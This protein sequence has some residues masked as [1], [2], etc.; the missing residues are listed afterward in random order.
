MTRDKAIFL[1]DNA[2]EHPVQEIT[3]KVGR[4]KYTCKT[5]D[6][7]AD[8]LDKKRDLAEKN[9]NYPYYK[10]DDL[11]LMLRLPEEPKHTNAWLKEF[12]IFI[13]SLE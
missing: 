5:R 11:L 3:I 10:G 12:L 13:M 1:A 7:A 2:I 9:H 8:I 6:E 4:K